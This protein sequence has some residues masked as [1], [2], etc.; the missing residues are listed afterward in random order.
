MSRP[1]KITAIVGTYRQG[2]AIDS[3]VEEILAGAH[4]AGATVATIRLI[5]QRIEFCTNCRVCTQQEGTSRGKCPIDDDLGTIL[6]QIE[7][8][9]ALVFA[10]PMNFW[11]VT[12][13]T[14]RFIER[15][16][17]Y[18]YWPWGTASPRM[19]S[20]ERK[21]H[22]LIVASS[23]APSLIARLLTP[24]IGHMKKVARLLGAGKIDVL[25]IGLAAVQPRPEL[26]ARAKAKGRRLGQ[27]LA[28]VVEG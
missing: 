27:S 11:S 12:A 22:A 23:A 1:A 19:R 15:L 8:S 20:A 16:V 25:F 3:A 28:Q 2:G 24:M 14:K 4:D 6:D 5:D 18:A 13:V 9:D 17:C 21:K 10:S 26:S 7:Q